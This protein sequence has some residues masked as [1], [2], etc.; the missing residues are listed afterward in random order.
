MEDILSRL[1]EISKEESLQVSRR[2]LGETVQTGSNSQNCRQF[3]IPS[4]RGGREAKDI[5]GV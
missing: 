3:C 5:V 1:G 4:A 2:P